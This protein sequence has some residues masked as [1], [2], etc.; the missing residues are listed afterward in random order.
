M[1]DSMTIRATNNAL[2]GFL[3]C[4][5]DTAGHGYAALL[6]W[7]NVVQMQRYWMLLVAAVY[8][9][10]IQFVFRDPCLDGLPMLA[11]LLS[12]ASLVGLIV[13]LVIGGVLLPLSRMNSLVLTI[14][15][16]DFLSVVCPIL[17]SG[18]GSNFPSNVRMILLPSLTSSCK[19][20]GMEKCISAPSKAIRLERI[21]RM[22]A[23]P[24]F[25]VLLP[26]LAQCE[27]I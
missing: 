16:R 13:L 4:L 10:T 8:A 27:A 3:L 21:M 9:T 18:S 22:Q 7:L 5:R 14:V 11:A 6:T 15:G 25:I 2:L 1:T 12:E 20:F 24:F 17:T 23:S 19:F 26:L